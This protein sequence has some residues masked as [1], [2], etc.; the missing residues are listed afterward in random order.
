MEDHCTDRFL[1]DQPRNPNPASRTDPQSV[2]TT[3]AAV[4]PHG[5]GGRGDGGRADGWP[6]PPGRD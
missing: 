6:G 1:P 3:A 2:E 4:G 5:C